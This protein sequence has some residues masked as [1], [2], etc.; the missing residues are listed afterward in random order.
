MSDRPTR[1][2]I[3]DDHE[4]LSQG[5]AL[6]L[7]SLGHEVTVSSE[8]SLAGVVKLASTLLPRLVLLDLQLGDLGSGLDVIAP[9]RATGADVLM[10]TGVT[11][12][13]D[14]GACIEAG[15]MGV[16]AKTVAFD[17]LLESINLA[18]DGRAG[19]PAERER[20]VAALHDQRAQRGT[21]LEPFRSLTPREEATLALLVEGRAA[22]AI[23]EQTFV[24]LATVRSHIRSILQKLGVNSQLAAVALARRAGWRPDGDS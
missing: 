19:P 13:A 5:V 10:L 18:F 14:L 20:W 23:A 12:E 17:D 9:L 15:A 2:L 11:D 8:S 4:L 1:I 3:V 21:A 24:S 7:R 22:E 6:A 16:V